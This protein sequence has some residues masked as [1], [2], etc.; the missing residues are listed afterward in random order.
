VRAF[1]IGFENDGLRDT[2]ERSAFLVDRDGIIRRTWRY[3][4]FELPNVDQLLEAARSL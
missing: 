1:D 3:E 4:V 2:A